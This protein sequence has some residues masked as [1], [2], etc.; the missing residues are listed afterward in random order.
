MSARVSGWV[1][2]HATVKSGDLVVLLALADNAH[3]DGTGAYPSQAHLAK[4]ARMTERQVRN[5]LK[6][7]EEK[8]LIRRQG[9]TAGGVVVWAVVMTGSPVPGGKD[10]P[11]AIPDTQGGNGLPTEPSLTTH[12][13]LSL[14]KMNGDRK[15][16]GTSSLD[17][18][19]KRD[20]SRGRAREGGGFSHRR[21]KVS[22]ELAASAERVLSV[23]NDATGARFKARKRSG[24]PTAELKQIAGA[25]LDRE[26]VTEAEWAAGVRRMAECPPSWI[27]GDW[28]VGHMFGEKA[29]AHTVARSAPIAAKAGGLNGGNVH[30]LRPTRF[31]AAQE[32]LRVAYEDAVRREKEGMAG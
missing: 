32:S 25:M 11:P 27:E 10:Y 19:E 20:A 13:T 23:F 18:N 31:Q 8:S 1:W 14:S 7:L 17:E 4:K 12:S 24:E 6:S 16:V 22:P 30:A 26:D 2:D 21:R 5:C 9:S 29:S 28:I 15:T 3:D